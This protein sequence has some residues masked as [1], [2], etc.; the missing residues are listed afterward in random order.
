MSDNKL[1]VYGTGTATEFNGLVDK[2]N[3]NH[4]F[5]ITRHPDQP[6]RATGSR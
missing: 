2:L 6:R 4:K 1:I 3:E 5:T